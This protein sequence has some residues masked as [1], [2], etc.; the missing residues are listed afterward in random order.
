MA[1]ISETLEAASES[2]GFI[3]VVKLVALTFLVLT[4]VMNDDVFPRRKYPHCE[5]GG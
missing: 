3:Q 5:S 4:F 1:N 2:S